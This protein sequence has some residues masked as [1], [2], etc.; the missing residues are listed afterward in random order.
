MIEIKNF[1]MANTP[2]ITGKPT[3]EV[4]ITHANEP[5]VTHK[6]TAINKLDAQWQA[7]QIMF[8]DDPDKDIAPY[9]THCR[10][11]EK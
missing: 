8:G 3:H 5:S 1:K 7:L 10:E 11:V 9:I 4:I 2:P 6:V